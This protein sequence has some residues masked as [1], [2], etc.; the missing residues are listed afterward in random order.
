[1]SVRPSV[2][3]SVCPC[4]FVSKVQVAFMIRI[5][6]NLA[7]FTCLAQ[8]RTLLK[9][10]KIGSDLDIAPIYIFVRFY[11][12][13]VLKSLYILRFARNLA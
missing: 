7:Q 11:V 2:R 8:G 5:G 1:M 13:V 9:L 3:L 6:L 10:G 12:N 4:I